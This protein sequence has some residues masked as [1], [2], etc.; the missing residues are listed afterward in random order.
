MFS[1]L[2]NYTVFYFICMV[3]ENLSAFNIRRWVCQH[4]EKLLIIDINCKCALLYTMLTLFLLLINI[5]IDFAL[6]LEFDSQQEVLQGLKMFIDI[7][8]MEL[9]T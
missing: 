7:Q 1:D 3:M 4:K 6:K 2:K 5:W 9:Y 8:I